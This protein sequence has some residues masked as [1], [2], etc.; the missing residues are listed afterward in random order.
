MD[1][2]HR[3]KVREKVAA[4]TGCSNYKVDQFFIILT[5]MMTWTATGSGR[6]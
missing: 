2:L 6:R 4:T 3:G 5:V 1:I